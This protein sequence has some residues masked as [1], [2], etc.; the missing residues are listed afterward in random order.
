MVFAKS[1]FRD[2]HQPTL[3]LFARIL[4]HHSIHLAGCFIYYE[5]RR[6]HYES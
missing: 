2:R 3:Y 4:S 5:N 1:C 6:Y